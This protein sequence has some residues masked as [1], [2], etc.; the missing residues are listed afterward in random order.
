M[1]AFSVCVVPGETIRTRGTGSYP[2]SV[3]PGITVTAVTCG[4]A[5]G[6]VGWFRAATPVWVMAGT[7]F[8]GGF[9]RSNHLTS[10]STLAFADIPDSWTCPVCGADKADFFQLPA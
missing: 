8:L 10:V 2:N 6:A 7:L 9:L 1:W 3:A 5:V 4:V